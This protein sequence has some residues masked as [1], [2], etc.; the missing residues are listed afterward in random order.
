LA[1]FGSA[2]ALAFAVATSPG[3]AQLAPSAFAPENVAPD[4]P[5]GE[6]PVDPAAVDLANIAAFLATLTP[7][8]VTELQ[9]RCVVVT[10]NAANYNEAAVNLCTAVVEQAEGEMAPAAEPAGP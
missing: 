10:G 6:L 7:E 1:T 5:F 4:N 8:Q 3:Y 9:Q 2:A